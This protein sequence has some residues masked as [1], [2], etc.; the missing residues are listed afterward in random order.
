MMPELILEAV[1]ERPASTGQLAARLGVHRARIHRHTCALEASGALKR[2]GGP[3]AWGAWHLGD[4]SPESGCRACGAPTNGRW[5][6]GC[7]NVCRDDR[8]LFQAATITA[9][10]QKILG[11]TV[12]PTALAAKF[13]L[14][15]FEFEAD[16][17]GPVR[18]GLID[19]LLAEE[20]LFDDVEETEWARRAA[21]QSL[22]GRGRE[23]KKSK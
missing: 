20:G 22:R 16:A 8:V 2:E 13:D 1:R 19:Y 4:G 7:V 9:R 11:R 23:G 17:V 12:S 3:G 15:L 18:S 21:E 14:P 5:C 6:K 10:R